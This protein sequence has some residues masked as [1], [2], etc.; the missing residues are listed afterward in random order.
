MS[1]E[2]NQE[3]DNETESQEFTFIEAINRIDST[4][5]GVLNS[6]SIYLF[7]KY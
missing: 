5:K 7:Y 2:E 3:I 1:Q 4:G 6:C